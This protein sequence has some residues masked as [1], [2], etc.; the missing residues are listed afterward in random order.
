VLVIVV[1]LFSSGALFP[2]DGHTGNIEDTWLLLGVESGNYFEVIG[3]KHTYFIAPTY[4][5]N[6]YWFFKEKPFGIYV[7]SAGMFPIVLHTDF[8]ND[9]I[10]NN[11]MPFKFTIGTG[12]RHYFNQKLMLAFGFGPSNIWYFINYDNKHKHGKGKYEDYNDSIKLGIGADLV[13]NIKFAHNVIAGFGFTTNVM[14]MNWKLD[15]NEIVNKY[16]MVG[17]NPYIRLV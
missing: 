10:T 12:V 7:H 15:S 17:V 9:E 11:I 1:L 3:N 14:L 5:A 4:S 13:L 2:N 8:A 16:V 6:M